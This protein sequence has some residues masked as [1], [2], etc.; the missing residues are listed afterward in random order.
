M[1]LKHYAVQCS[2]ADDHKLSSGVY[3]LE[4]LRRIPSETLDLTRSIKGKNTELFSFRQTL[5]QI[6]CNF[7]VQERICCLNI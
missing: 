2:E 5:L 1:Q 4:Q 3:V 6:C 7:I